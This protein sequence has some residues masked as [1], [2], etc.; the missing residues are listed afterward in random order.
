MYPIDS[1]K[2]RIGLLG[3]YLETFLTLL[4]DSHTDPHL[5][6]SAKDR[7]QCKVGTWTLERNVQCRRR[8]RSVELSSLP[9]ER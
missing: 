4:A 3:S 1:I 6:Y 9:R 7:L 2:V 5:N 8:S